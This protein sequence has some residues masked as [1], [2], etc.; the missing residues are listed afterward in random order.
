MIGDPGARAIA[1]CLTGHA[2]S[3]CAFKSVSFHRNEGMTDDGEIAIARA[4]H[5]A[6]VDPSRYASLVVKSTIANA[7]WKGSNVQAKK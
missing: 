3:G 5:E 4:M 2:K 6:K 7:R 1:S